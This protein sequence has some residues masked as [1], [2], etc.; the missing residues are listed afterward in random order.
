MERGT[1]N[2]ELAI[3]MEFDKFRIRFRKRGDLR[4]LSHHDLMRTFERMLR[5]A[6]LPFRSTEGFHPHPRLVF[7]LSLPLGTIGLDEVVELEFLT[8]MPPEEVFSRLVAQAPQGIEFASIRRIPPRLTG[9]VCRAVY[10]LPIPASRFN[11]T[12]RLIA[13]LLAQ[14]EIS[15]ER[16][17]PRPKRVDIRPYLL[18]IRRT[19]DAVEIDLRVTATGSARADEVLRLLGLADLL[20]A[21]AILERTTLELL[22]E[23]TE[24]TPSRLPEADEGLESTALVTCDAIADDDR[25]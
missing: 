17:H 14:A 8:E 18:D 1:W 13:E 9:Q 6:A 7:A 16:S 11:E 3:P 2:V 10:R 22:D 20:D 5:R 21:G 23:T 12:E 19:P 25:P 15:V 4:F 24:H